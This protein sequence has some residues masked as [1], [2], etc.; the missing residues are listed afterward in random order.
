VYTRTRVSE[1]NKWEKMLQSGFDRVV[2]IK[3]NIY[4]GKAHL[5]T[6]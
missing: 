3:I 5:L 6:I 1:Y 4:Y 2:Q